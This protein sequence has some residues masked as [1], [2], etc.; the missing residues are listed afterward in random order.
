MLVLS[1]QVC[2]DTTL[3]K[4]GFQVLLQQPAAG[5]QSDKQQQLQSDGMLPSTKCR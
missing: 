1:R 2:D 4:G 3:E 5:A